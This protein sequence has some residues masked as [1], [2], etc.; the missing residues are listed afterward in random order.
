[1]WRLFFRVRRTLRHLRR[2]R[3]ITT[4]LLRYGL[5]DIAYRLDPIYFVQRLL[6]LFRRR[7]V[8]EPARPWARPRSVRG[9]LEE[10]GPCFIKLGQMLS[11]RPDIIPAA[12]IEE[13]QKL[14]DEVP[15]EGFDD[16]LRHVADEPLAQALAELLDDDAPEPIAAAS[17]AQVHRARL[18]SGESIA[19]K[20]QRPRVEKLFIGDLD[21]LLDVARFLDRDREISETYEPI[22]LV[23]ELKRSVRRETDFLLEGR[24]IE[25][26]RRNY[27]NSATVAIPKV[28]WELTTRYVLALEYLDGFSPHDAD[29]LRAA[30]H[31]PRRLAK[32]LCRAVFQQVFE[33]GLFHADPHPGN[34]LI[35]ENGKI[36]FLDYG[37][38][39]TLDEVVR[40]QVLEFSH[41]LVKRDAARM[42]RIAMESGQV[43]RDVDHRSLRY[44]VTAFLDQYANAPLGHIRLSE[45]IP[46]FLEVI[47]R[48][49]I[50]LPSDLLLLAKCVMTTEGVARHLDPNV[51]IL[52]EA[53]PSV[54]RALRARYSPKRLASEGARA[55]REYATFLR[56]LPHQIGDTLERLRTGTLEV[57]YRHQGLEE[58]GRELDRSTNR[59]ACALLVA[60]LVLA[61]SIVTHARIGPFIGELPAL[62]IAGYV[63]SL[64]LGLWLIVGILRSG[65]L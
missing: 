15:A 54:I 35:L 27:A 19:L 46:Q 45:A 32:N 59:L 36:A 12:Y 49:R 13:L 2:L 63:A 64:L 55:I 20:L 26:F 33:Y 3:Q 16:V 34:L 41:A 58:I 65:R 11:T 47:R 25:R 22:Q 24:T 10:L 21:I 1:M 39:G 60:A 50:R 7:S 62:G 61:S 5:S 17:M 30:G 18:K 28:H 38:V 48:H 56:H 52:K 6:R 37:I 9:A 31:D 23:E 43:P 4:I 40:N 42:I 29:E 51:D 53:R 14:Q 8:S 57:S 44:G